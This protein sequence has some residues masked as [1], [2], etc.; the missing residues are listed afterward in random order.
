M[1]RAKRTIVTLSRPSHAT[2]ARRTP[3]LNTLEGF[4][5]HAPKQPSSPSI[6]IGR[7]FRQGILAGPDY[8]VGLPKKN[9]KSNHS[10]FG[11]CYGRWEI[12][13]NRIIC[14]LTVFF[15]FC[16]FC[17]KK[18]QLDYLSIDEDSNSQKYFQC[19]DLK[20]SLPK[21]ISKYPNNVVVINLYPSVAIVCM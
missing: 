14:A 7:S 17:R 11:I 19:T 3:P 13:I 18:E 5:S 10:N 6:E 8:L 15:Y 4:R 12:R 21:K 2:L 16:G 1:P 20:I 9:T